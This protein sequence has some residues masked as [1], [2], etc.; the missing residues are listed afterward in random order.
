MGRAAMNDD[1]PTV[2]EHAAML[3]SAAQRMGLP[4][5][6]DM[7]SALI[8]AADNNGDREQIR[9]AVET[10]HDVVP[11]A[12]ATQETVAATL[13]QIQH[14]S[15]ADAP[16]SPL[17]SDAIP[18]TLRGPSLSA[19]TPSVV[20]ADDSPTI[21]QMHADALAKAGYAVHTARDG[22]AALRQLANVNADLVVTDF[23][24]APMNGPALI[25][26]MSED[27][28]L[29]DT[30][31]ILVSSREPEDVRLQL[32]DLTV[33]QIIGKTE[34]AA[35]VLVVAANKACE[36][37][38]KAARPSSAGRILVAEDSQILRVVMRDQ[39]V[40]AGYEVIEASDGEE[41]VKLASTMH[42]DVALLDREMPKLDGF[43]ALDALK[44]DPATADLP[45]VF[46]SGRASADELADG[47][48]RGAHD[49]VRK[50]VE[51]AELLARI[52]TALRLRALRDELAVRNEEL[53]S[54][55]QTDVLTGLTNRRHVTQLLIGAVGLAGRHQRDLSV[56]MVDV[57]HFKSVN[58]NHGHGGGDEVLRTVAA[59]LKRTLRTEDT[60]ARWGG[61]EFLMILPDIPIA[62]AEIAAERLRSALAAE[63]IVCE[64]A[65]VSVT[66][67]FGVAE[68]NG[69]EGP[70]DLIAR[71]DAA[72]YAAKSG[73]RDRVCAAAAV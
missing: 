68:W 4:L 14:V 61:E 49:Y 12:V 58:D 9:Q 20:I 32:G 57:D 25:R 3:K 64:G 44:A 72:L 5:I 23:D 69:S 15:D 66:A 46:V 47:L 22:T 41:A 55:A 2:S 29:S 40:A 37:T 8:I 35:D 24:M 70:E 50:P 10:L 53:E 65:L 59:V 52:R 34:L 45:V 19:R 33:V 17:V 60:S 67:S 21:R 26:A 38:G 56:V 30:P 1:L 43:G 73:G 54:M 18:A 48:D 31:V 7:M 13:A 42:P 16:A 28:R 39:L 62:G 27:S 6:A 11:T 36:G 63:P 51:P 71:A